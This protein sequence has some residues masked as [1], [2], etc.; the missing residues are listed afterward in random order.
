MIPVF[1]TIRFLDILDILFFAF[2]L[3][4]IYM[5]VRG[6]V[7]INI[8]I[9]VIAIYLLWLLVKAFDMQLLGNFLGQVIGIGMIAI[10]IIFQ[11]E[12]RRFLLMMGSR[13][14]KRQSFFHSLFGSSEMAGQNVNVTAIIQACGNMSKT[15]T[16]ALIVL[17]R[18]ST[19][20]LYSGTGVVL[21]AEISA[22]LIE[23]VFFNGNPL[24]DGAM[25]IINGRIYAVRCILPVSQSLNMPV[26]QG[27][28]HRAA[29]GISEQNDSFSIVISE[30]TGEISY[31]E[32]GKM[33]H[34]VSIVDLHKK[35]EA[36]FPSVS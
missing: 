18:I 11:Q 12:I 35:L 13:Y 2:L 1:I 9:G 24:H 14:S 34:N 16:G 19:I 33:T 27:I 17:S 26:N 10:I 8:F 28:R 7:A 6:S 25:L 20:E 30:E 5:L 31:A 32:Y 15:K 22:S 36:E 21:N 23:S 29:L 4:Q 3:Y